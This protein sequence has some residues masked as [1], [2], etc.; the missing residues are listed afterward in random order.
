MFCFYQFFCVV[1]VSYFSCYNSNLNTLKSCILGNFNSPHFIFLKVAFKNTRL[2]ICCVRIWWMILIVYKIILKLS[3]N[4][5]IILSISFFSFIYPNR[6]SILLSRTYEHAIRH[7]K[8]DNL[9]YINIDWCVCKF[10]SMSENR[11]KTF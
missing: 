10:K 7:Q 4:A 1:M 11:I 2:N 9:K 5:K 3:Y 6:D 8:N